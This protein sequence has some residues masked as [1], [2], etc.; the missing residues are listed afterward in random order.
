MRHART[1]VE[2]FDLESVMNRHRSHR[3]VAH[4]GFRWAIRRLKISRR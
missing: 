1:F 2:L 4:S 3:M